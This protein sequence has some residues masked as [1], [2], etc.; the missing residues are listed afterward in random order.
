MMPFRQAK[1][2]ESVHS[3][4]LGLCKRHHNVTKTTENIQLYNIKPAGRGCEKG[5]VGRGAVG[6]VAGEYYNSLR[7][8]LYV[9]ILAQYFCTGI[10]QK[11]EEFWVHVLRT[12]CS[13]S[14][15]LFVDLVP[16]FRRDVGSISESHLKLFGWW[17]TMHDD[18][19]TP[20][21]RCGTGRR[22]WKLTRTRDYKHGTLRQTM[23]CR[24]HARPCLGASARARRQL[25]LR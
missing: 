9:E 11:N 12:C 8:F 23:L 22:A 7:E 21:P 17:V 4:F 18:D 2:V 19:S 3:K 20:H 25:C 5:R 1:L 13:Y 24:C 10:C 15:F 14:H 6:G 16:I